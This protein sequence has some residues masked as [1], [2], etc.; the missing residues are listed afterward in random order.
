M[1]MSLVL[2]SALWVV[3]QK[4]KAVLEITSP[5]EFGAQTCVV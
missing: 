3:K 1:E 5:H 2:D 4:E